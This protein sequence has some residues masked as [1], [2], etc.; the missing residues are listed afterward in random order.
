MDSATL[1]GWTRVILIASLVA[2]VLVWVVFTYLAYDMLND[3]TVTAKDAFPPVTVLSWMYTPSSEVFGLTITLTL[4]AAASGAAL[5]F[6]PGFRNSAVTTAVAAVNA[7]AVNV[8]KVG[9]ALF[10]RR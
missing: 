7:A 9:G 3:P 1:K 6:Y 8:A 5:M 2:F 4:L 10:R